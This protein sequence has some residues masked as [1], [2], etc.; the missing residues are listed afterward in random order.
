MRGSKSANHAGFLHEEAKAWAKKACKKN[1]LPK[2]KA[3][4]LVAILLLNLS[5]CAG[6]PYERADQYPHQWHT[7]LDADYS[8]G[9]LVWVYNPRIN[10]DCASYWEGQVTA[11]HGPTVTDESL[12][13]FIGEVYSRCRTQSSSPYAYDAID[14]IDL[15]RQPDITIRLQD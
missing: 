11:K 14:I 12:R 4:V 1:P 2:K 10:V 5:A 13:E 8:T 9:T 3:K 15:I 7:V 6:E